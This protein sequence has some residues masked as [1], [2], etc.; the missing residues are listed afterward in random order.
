MKVIF[1]CSSRDI[2]ET[3]SASTHS[4]PC[5]TNPWCL[6][7]AHSSSRTMLSCQTYSW[8][9]Q[10]A[11]STGKSAQPFSLSTAVVLHNRT[12]RRWDLSH[13]KS[14]LAVKSA[15]ACYMSN[16]ILVVLAHVQLK[17]VY[18]PLPHNRTPSDR[19]LDFQVLL[20]RNVF[21]PACG[22]CTMLQGRAKL[23]KV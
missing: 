6:Q 18:K 17:S 13:G 4:L 9:L 22:V 12:L 23:S 20:S 10:K 14:T 21:T 2:Q 16:N 3:S 8:C 7:K 15:W 5:H 1:G 11:H 19:K